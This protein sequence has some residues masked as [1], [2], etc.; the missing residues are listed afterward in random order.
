ML[1]MTKV[2]IELITDPNIHLIIKKGIRRGR[3]EPIYYHAKANNKY[4]NPN[5]NK[6]RDEESYIISLD[7][8]SLYSLAMTYKLPYEEPTFD[9]DISKYT[10]NHILN[11]DENGDYFYIFNVDLHYPKK[12]H[13]RDFE[14]PLFCD[15]SIPPN[16]KTKKLMST[17]YDKKIIRFH[18]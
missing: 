12:L 11:L 9:N 13:D 18:F 14:F 17:Y 10:I 8:N 4:V 6:K 7:V 2:K 3:C 15:H 1:K 16:E 5:F